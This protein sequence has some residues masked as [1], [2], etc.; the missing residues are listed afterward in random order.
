MLTLQAYDASFVSLGLTP[1]VTITISKCLISQLL[2][3]F[4]GVRFPLFE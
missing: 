1:T 4:V 2:P 3:H